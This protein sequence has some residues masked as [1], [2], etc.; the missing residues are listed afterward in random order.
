MMTAGTKVTPNEKYWQ[1]K[2]KKHRF[3]VEIDKA[4]KF[5]ASLIGKIK[6]IDYEKRM[7]IVEW[8]N[9]LRQVMKLAQG[10]GENIDTNEKATF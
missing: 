8:E 9:N 4:I 6:E 1:V 3:G 7:A 5:P 2:L 10:P